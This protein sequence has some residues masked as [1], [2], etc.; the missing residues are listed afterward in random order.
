MTNLTTSEIFSLLMADDKFKDN[1]YLF[2]LDRFVYQAVDIENEKNSEKR[3]QIIENLLE[4]FNYLNKL[5]DC[6]LSPFDLI[7]IANI[8][9]RDKGIEG[10]RK[11]NVNAGKYAEWEPVPPEKIYS[12]LYSL[13][14]NYLNVWTD[15]DVYEKEALFHICL[16]RIHPF[17]DGNKRTF[18]LLLNANLIR[19]NIPPVVIGE[20]E[21]DMYYNFINNEDIEGFSKYIKTKSLQELNSMMSLYKN[22]RNIPIIDSL[23]DELS[24]DNT[25]K[26]G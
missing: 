3:K 10:I 20:A 16:M 12:E 2:F 24:A 25:R 14:D 8:V 6:K 18:K 4:A 26:N 7:D 1:Y 19:Q 9:N 21:T 23:T 15:R 17:E 11:I 5:D 13:F 22:I